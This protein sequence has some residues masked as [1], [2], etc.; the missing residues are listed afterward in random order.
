[1]RRWWNISWKITAF[2]SYNEARRWSRAPKEF[3]R[4]SPEG[5]AA[6][7]TTNNTVATTALVPLLSFGIW[8]D[9]GGRHGRRGAARFRIPSAPSGPRRRPRRP[10]CPGLVPEQNPAERCADH[11]H[12]EPH[13]SSALNSARV[14]VPGGAAAGYRAPTVE[15][16]E[17]TTSP[18]PTV[19]VPPGGR[20]RRRQSA[21]R[22]PAPW[23]GMPA[24]PCRTCCCRRSRSR[25]RPPKGGPGAQT[26]YH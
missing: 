17:K 5:V 10:G 4:G 13:A 2:L 20:V 16:A 6:P 11:G 18:P 23:A 3:G 1:M 7:E 26:G 19:F 8:P 22:G 14:L 9:A 25:S 12:R 15:S 24:S 21:A